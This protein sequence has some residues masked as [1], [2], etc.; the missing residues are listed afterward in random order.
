MPNGKVVRLDHPDMLKPKPEPA[1][2]IDTKPDPVMPTKLE[3]T[4]NE[5]NRAV[6]TDPSTTQAGIPTD[7]SEA[8]A[9]SSNPDSTVVDPELQSIRDM[10][11][12]EDQTAKLSHSIDVISRNP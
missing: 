7:Q 6:A 8:K 10:A 4:V 1:S 11:S 3:S 9:S 2:A 5:N 12:H